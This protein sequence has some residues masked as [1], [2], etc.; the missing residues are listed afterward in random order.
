MP[1]P[2]ERIAAV[3]VQDHAHALSEI[4]DAIRHL[5]QRMDAR[6]TAID[7]RFTAIDSRFTTHDTRFTAIDRRFDLLEHRFDRL[8]DKVSRQFMWTVSIQITVLIAVVSA[9]AAMLGIV[10]TRV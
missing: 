4:R 10:L 9:F 5:E 1:S 3:E 6:F 7:S 8:D 2:D